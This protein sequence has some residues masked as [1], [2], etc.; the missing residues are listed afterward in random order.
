M[1]TVAIDSILGEWG[2]L[3]GRE[4]TLPYMHRVAGQVYQDRNRLQP[5]VKDIY[6]AFLLTP[7]HQV[8]VVIVGQDPYP[9]GADGLAFSNERM[10]PS[11]RTIFRHLEDHG[12]TRTRT[13]LDDWASQGVLLLNTVLT[14]VTGQ[15]DAHKKLGWQQFTTAALTA[16]VKLEKPI[17][18]LCWGS[19]AISLVRTLPLQEFVHFM[20]TSYHPQA[21]NYNPANKFTGAAHMAEISAWQSDDPIHWGD[22]M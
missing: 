17:H 10:T 6:R 1:N 7:P 21:E 16:L 8:R 2:T 9:N 13:C 19:P 18:F 3:I 5:K 12:I 14:T 20:H 15:T 4:L 11:L 22:P